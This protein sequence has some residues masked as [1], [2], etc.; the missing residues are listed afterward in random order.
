MLWRGLSKRQILIVS[1]ANGR[2]FGDWVEQPVSLEDLAPTLV[3]LSGHTVP[4]EIQSQWTGQSLLPFL[5][6]KPKTFIPRPLFIH[7][8]YYRPDPLTAGD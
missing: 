7:E 3:A 4:S 2:K 5:Q 1:Y 6:Q 8:P